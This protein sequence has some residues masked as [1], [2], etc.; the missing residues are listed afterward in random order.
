MA[1]LELGDCLRLAN[2]QLG[3]KWDATG[4]G[5][6][7]S[8]AANGWSV[9]EAA[10]HFDRP[11]ATSFRYGARARSLAANQKANRV[12]AAESAGRFRL[13]FST[14]AALA[15]S[16]LASNKHH[17]SARA[18]VVVSVYQMTREAEQ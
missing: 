2:Q 15:V 1:P 16:S 13:R 14:S 3:N 6:L 8:R 17:E 18:I 10:P 5:G 7:A 9:N 4:P 12:L 11:F